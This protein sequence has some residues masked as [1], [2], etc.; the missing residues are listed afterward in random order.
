TLSFRL[1][2][3]ELRTLPVEHL[4]GDYAACSYFPSVARPENTAFVHKFQKRFGDHRLVTDSMESAYVAVHLWAR[5]AAKAGDAQPAAVR[6]A[7]PGLQTNGPGGPVRIDPGNRYS[8]KVARVAQ[9]GE[10]GTFKIVWSS[11]E[12]VEPKPFP[13]TRTREQWLRFLAGLQ[14]NWEGRWGR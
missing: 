4:K 10:R 6:P 2:E 3:S 13:S 5:A 1:G 11:E 12:P 7:L 9:I 14:H 8:W